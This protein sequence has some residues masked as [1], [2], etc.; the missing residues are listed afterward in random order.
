M[1]SVQPRMAFQS[2][3][4][5][6]EVREVTS[7][8]PFMPS[9]THTTL[10]MVAHTAATRNWTQLSFMPSTVAVKWS[11]TRMWMAKH[12]A[13]TSTSRS[14]G[15]SE[16]SPLM[17]S[18][19][20]AITDSPTAIHVA[21]FTF[22]L[23]SRPKTGT[24]TTYRAVRKPA[25][26]ASVPAARPACWKLEAMASAVPQQI[27]PSSSSRRF[28]RFCILVGVGL[29]LLNALKMA[30]MTNSTTTAM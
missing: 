25:L 29:S 12:T 27:P 26:P 14:P 2:G 9:S 11:I 20:S 21:R 1:G 13:H 4:A 30:M 7:P 10:A 24:S 15:A 22:R 17:H 5:K 18:R 19:Y 23:N 8:V 6:I 28:W 3:T 16:K